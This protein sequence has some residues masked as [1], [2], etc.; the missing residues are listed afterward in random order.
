VIFVE[1][2]QEIT[3]K[4]ED[5]RVR[6]L[7]TNIPTSKCV[8]SLF[9]TRQTAPVDSIEK[10]AERIKRYGF[11][12]TRALWAVRKKDTFEIFAG[13]LRLAGAKKAESN[14]D[15]LEHIGYSE[16]EIVALSDKD[17][18]DDEYHTK[19]SSVDMWASYARLRD[20]DWT[21]ERI[22]EAKGI[23]QNTVAWRLKLHDETS[24][25]VKE[26]I[27]QGLLDEGHL[28]EIFDL[29]VNGYLSP[30]LT[31]EEARQE[32]IDKTIS[33]ISKNDSK[34]TKA[35]REDVSKI[36]ALLDKVDE[37]YKSF[38][39]PEKFYEFKETDGQITA[40]ETTYDARK[41]FLTALKKNKVR[42]LTDAAFYSQKIKKELSEN[43]KKYKEHIAG[44]SSDKDKEA[45]KNKRLAEL[46]SK[47]L[48]EDGVESLQI[49]KD[50]TV[51]LLLVDPPYGADYQSNRRWNSE[52]RDKIA[53]DTEQESLKLMD[54]ILKK[55]KPKL[56]DDAHLLI[57]TNS[58]Q[59]C[60]LRSLIIKNE[61]DLKGELIWVKEEHG[62]GDLKGTFAP[63]HEYIVH[64]VMGKPEVTPRKPTVFQIAREHGANPKDHPME[65]PVELLKQLIESTTAKGQLVID[66]FAG[67]ASTL[68]AAQEMEREFWG[69]EIDK[70][71]WE[72]GI[73]RLEKVLS[74]S[75]PTN[76]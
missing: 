54:G 68:F 18:E 67:T 35:V 9:N 2:Q 17:N 49:L 16:D 8:V 74:V 29:S 57:F 46:R 30:W 33:H 11:E 69:C 39:D 26:S 23:A 31:T 76:I 4:G 21:Q 59:L 20:I 14:V 70:K 36:K 66:P 12:T 51:R 64:A 40:K 73:A 15:V 6:K 52:K 42:T 75:P 60:N 61:Y 65:K 56:M 50:K 38:E 27:R 13:G 34:S 58:K 28:H 19:V 43:L 3:I 72:N 1:K 32:L 7:W 44:K 62:T 45:E 10:L 25:K 41:Q 53:G 55:V 37:I 63:Q 24:T 48:N 71:H 22:A 47:F 5:D